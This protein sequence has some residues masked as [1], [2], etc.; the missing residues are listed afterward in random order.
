MI[1]GLVYESKAQGAS[2]KAI[3]EAIGVSQRSLQ[4]WL[5]QGI[6][7][8]RRHGPK[9]PPANKFS[10]KER[11]KLLET[12]NSKEYRDLSPWQI[13]PR[14]ADKGIFIGSEST[15]YRFLKEEK[16]LNHRGRAKEPQKRHKPRELV[17]TGPNQVWSWDITYLKTK[18]KGLYFYAYVIIDVFS[19][20]IVGCA[21]HDEECS[22]KASKLFHEVCGREGIDPSTLSVHSDNGS[23]MKGSS[24]SATLEELG[25]SKSFSRPRVSNDNPY[26]ESNFRTAKY[27]PEYPRQGFGSI[28]DAIDWFEWFVHWYN[29]VHRHSGIKFVTPEQRHSGQDIEILERRKDLYAAAR[30]LNPSRWSRGARDWS[31]QDEVILNP[32]SFKRERDAS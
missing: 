17:A 23:P 24:L 30:R 10:A 6:G 5:K 27:R 22:E 21:V 19:R 4:R 29:N 8:D 31:R 1:L 3:C 13:V 11:S 15:C 16:L 28:E 2:M 7:E 25:V 12:L 14:L 26:S 20:K 18:V 32:D 9:K